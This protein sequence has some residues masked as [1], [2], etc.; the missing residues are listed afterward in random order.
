MGRWT[1]RSRLYEPGA[2]SVD[3]SAN[4][5]VVVPVGGGRFV[6]VDYRWAYHRERQEGSL[7]VGFD[8]ATRAVQA[9]W[10]DS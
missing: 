2:E 7:L 9:V 10:I 1:G 6:R 4:T 3:E 5:A 8:P